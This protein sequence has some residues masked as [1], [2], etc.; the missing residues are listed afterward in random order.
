MKGDTILFDIGADDENGLQE[1]RKNFLKDG[2]PLQKV[3]GLKI[4]YIMSG[5]Q[6]V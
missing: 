1:L 2:E 3:S 5:I 4:N 6:P